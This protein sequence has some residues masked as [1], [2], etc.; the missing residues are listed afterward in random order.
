MASI[1]IYGTKKCK[2]TQKALRFFKERG[3]TPQ[4]FDLKE[5][6]L[7]EG[8]ADKITAYLGETVLDIDSQ[9][10]KKKFAYYDA[11]TKELITEHPELIKTPIVKCGQKYSCGNNPDLWKSFFETVKG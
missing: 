11:D 8:E 3:I 5:R 7:S 1:V 2:T 6:S 9:L 4:F 10:Y